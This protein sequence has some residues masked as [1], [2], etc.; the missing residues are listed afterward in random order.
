MAH[1]KHELYNITLLH[2]VSYLPPPR[3]LCFCCCVSVCLLASLCK[4]FQTHLHEIFREGW[5]WA[6]E[7]MVKF[8]WRSGSLSGYRG[9]FLDSSLL[10][11]TESGINRLHCATLQ[12][13][14]CT[15]RHRHNNYDVITSRPMTD[16]RADLK[17]ICCMAGLMS[18]QW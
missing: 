17:P 12:C 13:T 11:D 3:T 5:Q 10:G 18:R 16:F 8:R 7:Q 6:I 4:N 9:C 2:N 1:F 14:A 15:S